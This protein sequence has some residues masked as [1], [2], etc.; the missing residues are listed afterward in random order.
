MN[1]SEELETLVRECL[2]KG[3]HRLGETRCAA[4]REALDRGDLPMVHDLLVA[5][6]IEQQGIGYTAH[7]LR[8]IDRFAES[9]PPPR[10]VLH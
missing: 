9:S 3:R 8:E 6:M 5:S 10:R 2:K 1:G 4:L 7:M